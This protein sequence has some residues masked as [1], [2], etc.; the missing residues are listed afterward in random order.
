MDIR[1][2]SQH[3]VSEEVFRLLHYQLKDLRFPIELESCSSFERFERHQNTNRL[4]RVALEGH[5]D[6]KEEGE[7]ALNLSLELD[8]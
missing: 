6:Q 2:G 4:L 3:E 5:R 1:V 7:P 8:G